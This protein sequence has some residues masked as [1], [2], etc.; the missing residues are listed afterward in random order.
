MDLLWYKCRKCR[1]YLF[2]NN[3]LVNPENGH[4]P[5]SQDVAESSASGQGE[6]ERVRSVSDYVKDC[7]ETAEEGVHYAEGKNTK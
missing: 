3:H 1:T 5:S 2:S 7:Q 6:G 4:Q